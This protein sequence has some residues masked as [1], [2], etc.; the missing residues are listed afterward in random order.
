[1]EGYV[2][3]VYAKP[4]GTSRFDYRRKT[5]NVKQNVVLYP[6]NALT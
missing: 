2:F 6:S 4:K 5:A 1:M 3:E